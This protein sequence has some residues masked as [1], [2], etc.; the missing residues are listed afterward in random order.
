MVEDL[1]EAIELLLVSKV[2]SM[3]GA[4]HSVSCFEFE[5]RLRSSGLKFESKELSEMK[6]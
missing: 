3:P 1:P 4:R 2:N 6:G 5:N